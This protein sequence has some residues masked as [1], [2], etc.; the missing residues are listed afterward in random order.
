MMTLRPVAQIDYHTDPEHD[1][2]HSE[3]GQCSGRWA[4]RGALLLGLSGTIDTEGYHNVLQGYTPCK[5]YALCD[6]PGKGHRFGWD[7]VFSPDKSV[8]LLFAR[9]DSEEREAILAAQQEAVLQALTLLEDKAAITRRGYAGCIREAT[10]GLVATTFTH[11]ASRE[12]DVQLHTHLVVANVAPRSDYSWGTIESRDLYIWQHAAGMT[13][14]AALAKRLQA[15]G[16]ALEIEEDNFRVSGISRKLCQQF[17]TRS[18]QIQQAL[19]DYGQSTSASR[20]GDI[21]TLS[22]RQRKG[23]TSRE[24]LYTRWHKSLDQAGFTTEHLQ[25]LKQSV[26]PEANT[27]ILFDAAT[28]IEQLHQRHTVFREQDVYRSCAELALHCGQDA[29]AAQRLA[30]QIINDPQTRALGRDQRH[31]AI[32]TTEQQLQ[33]EQKMIANAKHLAQQNGYGITDQ[34]IQK[35]IDQAAF[36]LSDEQHEAVLDACKNKCFSVLQGSAGS[37][38]TASM[39][40]VRHAYEASGYRI[41]G[42]TLAKVASDNLTKETGIASQTIARLL[43]QIERDHSPLDERTVLVIDEAG[44]VECA[45]LAALLQAAREA[46]SK[47]I[48][49]GE[50]RQLDS[51]AQGGTLRYLSRPDIIGT[52]R[53]K[54]IRRQREAWAQQAVADWR[55]GHASKAIQAHQERGLIHIANDALSAEA[56]LFKQWCRYQDSHPEKHSLV[57]AQ[58]WRQV[59]ALNAHIRSHYQAQGKVGHED[60]VLDCAISEKN[61]LRCAFSTGERVRLCK[62][63]YARGFSN[64]MLGTITHIEQRDD[65]VYFEV[66]NDEGRTLQFSQSDYADEHGRLYLTQAYAMTIFSSQGLTVD[67]DTFVLHN[68]RMDRPHAY[69]AG[70]RHRDQC[71]WFINRK[72]V[73]MMAN[74]DETDRTITDKECLDTLAQTLSQDNYSSLATEYVE[75][76]AA[77]QPAPQAERSHALEPG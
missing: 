55:D 13:Y 14:R 56:S 31:S 61:S 66:L 1:D 15:L 54:T 63:D 58:H 53:V 42:A 59:K 3:D 76:Q 69:V 19:K 10:A 73:Q 33:A 28:V 2:Y 41:M 71:H 65:N 22:T 16:Y 77:L 45:Q 50:D 46:G 37:G 8:S 44:L 49:V 32:F 18:Q 60:I 29:D 34:V 21:A 68:S 17:S 43:D 35:A 6:R 36:P 57:L 25:T 67:G 9:A 75:K 74:I 11:V 72:E 26:E 51:I 47:V 27:L 20:A 70:S 38:K 23:K 24:V 30:R 48:L 4:S 5:Q 39:R 52:T 40:S 62:N 7:L 64:G 12:E